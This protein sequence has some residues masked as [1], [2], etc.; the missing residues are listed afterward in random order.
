MA[1]WDIQEKIDLDFEGDFD[2]FFSYSLND[3]K[4]FCSFGS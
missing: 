2:D 1:V 4:P 3:P